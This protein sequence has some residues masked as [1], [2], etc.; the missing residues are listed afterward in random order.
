MQQL[1][2]K[3]VSLSVP[4]II[5]EGRTLIPLRFVSEQMGYQVDWINSEKK[6]V[7]TEK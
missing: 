3:K 1:T 2:G 4:S 6:I 5:H 7:I